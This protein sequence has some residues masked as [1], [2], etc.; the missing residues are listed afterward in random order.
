MTQCGIYKIINTTNG[1]YYVG[2]SDNILS[3]WNEHKN[4]LRKQ[5]HQNIHLQR[6]WNK[7]G[8][9]NFEFLVVEEVPV[10][11]LL[12]TE[13]MYLTFCNK[14]VSYNI[15]LDA[16][17]P[18][19]GRKHSVETLKILMGRPAWNKGKH[20]TEAHKSKLRIP[21][22][23][24][25]KK[26]LSQP[27]TEEHKEKLKLANLGKILSVETKQKI[28][29]SLK[30]SYNPMYGKFHTEESRLKM[31]NSSAKRRSNIPMGAKELY[32]SGCNRV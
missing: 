6:A 10:N 16:S 17:A 21:K 22:T 32:L 28:S 4:D 2:S 27:K 25:W 9:I 24:E 7:Y 13:Q 19:R 23:D 8:E 26:K 30:G 29:D 31:R 12:V 15:S 5:K 1:K 20:L 14:N 3:R 18:M 11:K